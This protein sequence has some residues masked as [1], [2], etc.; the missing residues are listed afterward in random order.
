MNFESIV[1][2]HDLNTYKNYANLVDDEIILN[3]INSMQMRLHS[4]GDDNL[5]TFDSYK[6]SIH[7]LSYHKPAGSTFRILGCAFDC[8]LIMHDC[9]HETV[10]SAN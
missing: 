3:D 7:I 1:Y 6:E 5:V 4:W 8:K 10:L 2:A 9:V